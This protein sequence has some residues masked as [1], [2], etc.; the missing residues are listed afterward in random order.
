M[1]E[2]IT[3]IKAIE[4]AIWGVPLFV[5][6]I[7]VGVFLSCLLRGVQFRYLFKAYGFIKDKSEKGNGVAGDISPF[8]SLMTAMA[9]AVGTG[10]IV[11]VATAIMTGGLGSI[12]WMWITTLVSMSIKYSESLLAVKYRIVDSRGEMSGG[13]MYYIE[14]GLGWKWLAILFALFATIA[15][16]GTGN[17]IQ[18]NSIGEALNNVF[19]IDPLTTGIVL[20]VITA[21]ILFRGIKGIGFVSSF[22]V[23][24]MGAFYIIAGCVVLVIFYNKIPSAVSLILS[25]AFS[26]Q[27]ACGG[28]LGSTVMMGMQWGISR[29]VNSSEA[30]LGISSI[31]AAAARTASSGRQALLSMTATLLSTAIICTIT[32]LAIA[33]TGVMGTTDSTGKVLNGASLAIQ[34]FSSAV[35]GGEYIVAFGLVLFA[36]TTVIAWAYYGEKCAEY[37]FGAKS[38]IWYRILYTALVI[39]GALFALD[40]VWSFANI[41]NALMV[42]PNLVGI[43]ALSGVIQKE[44]KEFLQLEANTAGNGQESSNDE[45]SVSGLVAER[46]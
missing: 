36:Y 20:T 26:G 11:G 15:A 8:Q 38:V 31:A 33:V 1:S 3:I 7:G 25:S 29:S 30:G 40:L 28:F 24:I 10:G 41:M 22:L 19:H 43:L 13:P 9:S 14:R 27:A 23:P 39:P 37:L 34:A 32:A 5:L 16:I 12:F 45:S 35:F 6:L 46:A 42:I 2:L 4:S 44:T 21:L 18:I 17:L